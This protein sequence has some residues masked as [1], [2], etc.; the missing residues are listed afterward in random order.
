MINN[1]L[2]ICLNYPAQFFNASAKANKSQL[3]PR[4]NHLIAKVVFYNE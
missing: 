3:N 1:I 2:T 4:K